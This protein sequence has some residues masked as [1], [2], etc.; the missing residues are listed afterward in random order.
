MTTPIEVSGSEAPAE[1]AAAV[2]GVGPIEG[3]SLGQIAWLRLKRDK[4]AMAG[5]AVIIL[6]IA[7]S[8][9]APVIVKL[10]GH[11]PNEFHYDQIQADTQL[12]VASHGGVSGSF[13][14]GVEPVN[15]RD[16]FS[17]VV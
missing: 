14:F 12:P 9:L 8:V 5:A 10:L 3:R 13:L 16:L 4:V 6:L 1:P 17:R 11:P 7:A 2:A 15:G